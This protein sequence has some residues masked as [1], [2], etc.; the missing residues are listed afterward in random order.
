MNKSDYNK[1][2]RKNNKEKIKLYNINYRKTHKEQ[3]RKYNTTW[4]RNHRKECRES[5]SNYKKNHK[6]ELLNYSKNYYSR[7]G[8]RLF[9]KRKYNLSLEQYQNLILQQNNKCGICKKPFKQT[10]HIDHNH[11]TGMVRGLLCSTC[12]RGIGYFKDNIIILKNAID[13]LEKDKYI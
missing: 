11:Q 9:L 5:N 12:N 2:Y 10:A 7:R 8:R 1:N 4:V 13:Y 6:K 3:I